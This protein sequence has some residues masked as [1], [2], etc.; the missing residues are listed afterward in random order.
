MSTK[1]KFHKQDGLYFISFAV[2]GWID[3]FIRNEY[4]QI[5]LDSWQYCQK[6]KGLQIYGWVIM[7]SHVHMIIGTEKDDMQ[8]I[9]RDMKRH[10]SMALRNAISTHPQE[11][12]REWILKMM[13]EAGQLNSN[14]VGFQL[15]RQDNHPIE[16]YT[17]DMMH[18]KLDYI[19]N[20][21]V[22][23]GFV[24]NAEHYL[25]SSARDYYNLP[26]L[27]PGV[28]KINPHCCE[29]IR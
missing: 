1:Y 10:T 7:T 3:L 24:E 28:I 29:L 15:W 17:A 18:Q 20:N 22:T 26:S 23:A 13:Q 2:V 25:F 6:Q 9:V 5:L 27:L 21:P 16:L 12:R 11:S 19:H 8:N 4:K 14:N